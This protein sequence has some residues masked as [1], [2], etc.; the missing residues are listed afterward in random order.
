MLIFQLYFKN[1]PERKASEW[2]LEPFKKRILQ[3]MNIME[4]KT[5]Q[6]N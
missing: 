3:E 1:C 6:N 5:Q 4:K 2:Q